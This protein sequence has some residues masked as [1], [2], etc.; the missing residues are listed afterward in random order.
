[1]NGK[2][3]AST[4]TDAQGRYHLQLHAGS[5]TLVA[6]TPN[7]FPRCSPVSVSVSANGTTRVDISCDTGI[8]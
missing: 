8:R 2:V 1:M 4:P 5:Y 3:V 6:V 7:V